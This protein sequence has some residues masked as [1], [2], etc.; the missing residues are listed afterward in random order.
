ME[1]RAVTMKFDS[2]NLAENVNKGQTLPS[3]LYTDP[4]VFEHEKDVIFRKQWLPVARLPSLSRSACPNRIAQR[5]RSA[6][7]V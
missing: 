5:C 7:G 6:A 2:L 4:D 3:H 1:G